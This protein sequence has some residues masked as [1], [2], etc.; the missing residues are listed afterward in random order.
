MADEI[1]PAPS[2]G[3][4]ELLS[5]GK[6]TLLSGD[7]RDAIKT[8]PDNSIDAVVTDP[9]Y[10]LVSISKRFGAE[11]AV[12][13]KAGT[14]YA[15]A[16]S[17]FMG[18][19]WDTG[20]VAFDPAFWAEVWRVLKPGGHVVSFG[21]TRTY[22]RMACAIED[23]G[24][25]I[26]DQI[27]WLYGTGF[28]KS[29]DVS[30]GIDKRG[31][32]SGLT[33]TIGEAIRKARTDRGLTA[34]QCDKQFCDGSTNWSW[35]EGRA[36]GQR[37]PTPE[38]FA[39][40]VAEW[41]ELSHLAEAVAEADREITGR[42][43]NGI[44]GGSGELVA[45]NERTA[46]F[47]AEFDITAPATD[48]ARQWS[49]WGTALK[50]AVE[51]IVLARK[52]LSESTVAANVLRWGTGAI[53]IDA[54]R[55]QHV[56]VAGGNLAQNTH[57]RASVHG[58]HIEGIF[59]TDA[60][61]DA[62]VVAPNAL[63][64]WPANLVLDGSDEV[65]ALFP[66]SNAR[67]PGSVIKRASSRDEQGN[68]GAAYG[69]E[70]RPAGSVMISHGDSGS[71]ARFFF[72][73][74]FED[75]EKCPDLNQPTSTASV[76]ESHF[77]L[78]SAR[79]VS[80]LRSVV[81]QSTQLLALKNVSFPEPSMSV[82]V[83]QLEEIEMMLTGMIQ[84]LERRYSQEP[85]QEKHFLSSNLVSAAAVRTPTGIITITISLWKSNGYAEA[86]I[87]NFT[88]T[89][90]GLGDRGYAKRAFYSA[91]A[92]KADRA[93]SKHPTVKPIKLMQW[94]IRLIT[95]PGGT[96]LDPFAGSGSTGAAAV[97]E[98]ASAV[99]IEREA[100]YQSDIR[101]RFGGLP[102]PV[103]A[104]P[105]PEPEQPVVVPTP[106]PE[107]EPPRAPVVTIAMRIPG[108]LRIVNFMAHRDMTE[109]DVLAQIK[110]L[111]AA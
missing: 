24:F 15:R 111:E 82:S 85:P 63:G 37:A 32:N 33:A 40:I 80:A 17:G 61:R 89:N 29:H 52:P 51:P 74:S 59:Q 27:Q 6:V 95:P 44:A 39:K 25:E 18:R 45:G 103:A 101:R 9:P 43:D 86:V 54:C 65:T 57:L 11:N 88:E 41:P 97:A 84:N 16:S 48:A 8:L 106:E 20:E 75:G 60:D 87:L 90:S 71:A 56:T 1:S 69:A 83:L 12:P 66:E 107:P 7:C 5:D 92:S 94:L 70:S 31:G 35:F 67:L 58:R 79:A 91:K 23:A 42:S 64:R 36:A 46:G 100:E 104:A 50:P 81:E 28:P 19:T 13:A 99:L 73:A 72:Q 102:E 78:S 96:V 22:H 108:S 3:T 34:G 26:R 68:T 98:G 47:K 55:V 30:K 77:I 10:A 93:G 62:H 53:N 38:T 49:G 76:A 21:G 110:Q 2:P 105:E 4:G 109:T 14:V